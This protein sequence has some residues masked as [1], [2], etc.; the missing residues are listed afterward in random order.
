VNGSDAPTVLVMAAGEGTR[1]HSSLPKALH[2]VCGRPL[3]S[4]PILAAREA[5]AA[6]IVAIVSPQRD[7]SAGL[8]EGTEIVEQPEADGTGGA[9]RAAIDVI[10]DS[11]TVIVLSAD[12]PVI[13]ADSISALLEAH[14]G[15]GA[16]ATV[17]TAELDEPGSYGRIVRDSD[18]SL[19]R[20]VEAK[21]PGDATPEELAITEVNTGTYAF[22]AAPLAEALDGISNDNSQ[23]EYYLGDVLPLIRAAG[24]QVGAHLADDEG[25]TLGVNTRLDLSRATAVARRRILEGHMLAGVTVIDPAATWIDADV[26]IEPDVTIEP[27]TSLRG[28]TRIGGGSVVGP[29]TTLID[30]ALG[31][32][33]KATHSYLVDCEVLDG[34]SV[35][36]FTHIRP[37][38]VMQ[39]G[40]KAGSFVELKNAQI[41]EG[42]KVPHLSYVGDA[43][44]GTGANI[45]A[46]SIT[47]NYDGFRKHRTVVGDHCRIGVDTMFVAPV[48]IGDGAYT[49]AGTV[50]RKDVPEGALAVP[51]ENK[52]RHIDDYA[53]R[54]AKQAEEDQESGS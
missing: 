41:G 10:R 48:S 31:R 18:G 16:A 6:R 53:E 49:G 42:A 14:A 51:Q 8:P 20:I 35:G 7:I 36:P 2:E 5:G 24:G 17:L 54:R 32:E 30:S 34:C 11:A 40:A 12:H 19:A 44:I 37:Q 23:G 50:V 28:E 13:S 52:Q 15:D 46:G 3:V 1:M 38:T 43:E 25:V 45:G 9:I 29:N 26:E 33:V 4:W 21:S 22:D 39:P 27:G 47:A